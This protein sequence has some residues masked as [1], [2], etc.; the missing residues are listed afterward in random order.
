MINY[1]PFPYTPDPYAIDP[2]AFIA[3][4]LQQQGQPA[5]P[6]AFPQMTPEQK[7]FGPMHGALGD[8]LRMSIGQQGQVPGLLQAMTQNP[9][10]AQGLG[11]LL[12]TYAFTP[13][14]PSPYRIDWNAA[15]ATADRM[16]T[17]MAK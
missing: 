16:P 12:S 9:Q 7:S 14:A 2:M 5:Q 10:M 15:A 4:A 17:G 1:Y 6:A 11:G 13:Q 3:Q 8:Y